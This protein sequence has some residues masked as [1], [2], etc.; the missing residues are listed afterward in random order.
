MVSSIRPILR[1]WNGQQAKYEAKGL[2]V[3]HI[4]SACLKELV[5]IFDPKI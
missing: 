2:A 3:R 5:Y 4:I 1:T